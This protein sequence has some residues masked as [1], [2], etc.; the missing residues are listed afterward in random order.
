MLFTSVLVLYLWLLTVGGLDIMT[1]VCI[2]KLHCVYM[3]FIKCN[4]N[5]QHIDIY[6]NQ[7]FMDTKRNTT[8][9]HS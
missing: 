2:L 5:M 4:R 6:M 7:L 9:G 1:N 3:T 8:G